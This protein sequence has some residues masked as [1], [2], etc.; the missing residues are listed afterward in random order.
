MIRKIGEYYQLVIQ[1]LVYV[2]LQD[3]LVHPSNERCVN[4]AR[5][6]YLLAFCSLGIIG[7]I[8]ILVE[9]IL[10]QI[11]IRNSVN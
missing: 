8:L 5:N 10:Q 7:S 2:E 3:D 6:R 1:E 4:L 9:F 11:C